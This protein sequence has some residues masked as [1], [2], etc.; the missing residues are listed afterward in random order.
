MFLR[1][2]HNSVL[3]ALGLL[4][5][6]ALS[7]GLGGCSKPA[8]PVARPRPADESAGRPPT[9]EE[10]VALGKAMSDAINSGDVAAL[11]RLIDW[12]SVYRRCTEGVD[13]TEQYRKGFITGLEKSRMQGKGVGQGIVDAVKKGGSY[14]LLHNHTRR[15]R[16]RLLFRL[17][18][19][20]SGA[21]YHDFLLARGPDGKVK[22]S[23]LYVYMSGELISQTFRRGY[24]LSLARYPEGLVDRLSG[25]DRKYVQ[26]FEKY[27]EMGKA[28]R[29]GRYGDVLDIY[30]GFPPELKKEKSV[31]ML[32]L[33]SAQQLGDDGEYLRSMEDFRAE[34]PSDESIDLISID[35]YV[36]KKQYQKG[37]ACLDRLD[38]AVLGDPYLQVIRANILTEL[39]DLEAAHAALKKAVEAEPGL[40]DAHWALVTLSLKENN[41]A[42]TLDTLRLIRDEFQI[43]MEDLTT[44]PAYKG[45]TESPQ[46]QEWL[47]DKPAAVRNADGDGPE[48]KPER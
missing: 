36:V 40:L 6:V 9:D 45:F 18:I 44:L 5:S 13:A 31:L 11:D 12:D 28:A 41:H 16:P 43:E 29:E 27:G 39:G 20:E 3:F 22:A 10:C 47:K 23:D 38:R 17:L 21:N 34:Y 46:Y 33:Q 48:E 15:E 26:Y 1:L 42:E 24:I 32:R 2:P 19:P 8:V 7:T 37:L 25:A 30:K 35:Y 14:T 4:S